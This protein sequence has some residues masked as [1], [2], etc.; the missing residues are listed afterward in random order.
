M[1]DND[2]V[3]GDSRTN[4]YQTGRHNN[5]TGSYSEKVQ[6]RVFKMDFRNKER[7]HVRIKSGISGKWTRI[8]VIFCI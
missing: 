5:S 8:K 6:L 7:Y 3:S 1:T 2:P 4:Y